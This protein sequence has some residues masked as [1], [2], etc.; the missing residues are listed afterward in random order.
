MEIK[1][2]N[3]IIWIEDEPDIALEDL[4]GKSIIYV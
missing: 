1:K 2:S 3:T 4:L